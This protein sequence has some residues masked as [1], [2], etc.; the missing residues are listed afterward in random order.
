MTNVLII[1]DEPPAARRLAALIGKHIADAAVRHATGLESAR[2]MLRDAPADMVFLDLN[3]HGRDGFRILDEL[4]SHT[5]VIVVSANTDRA[6]EAFDHGVS[7][8]VAKPV[9][10]QRL[11]VAIDRA[12]QER[13]VPAP[14]LPLRSHRGIDL[15]AFSDITS[16]SAL[17][18]YTEVRTAAGNTYIED[19]SLTQLERKCAGH[20]I[21]IHRSHMV[22]PTHVRDLHK[23]GSKVT[24]RL[25]DGT[26]LPVSRRRT[27]A[28]KSALG[29]IKPSDDR[30]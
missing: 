16:A 29:L 25:S 8:F 1:E 3:L 22:N 23:F 12:R 26:E 9:A 27:R 18:D 7:D 17:D 11:K 21:R 5:A 19:R 20:L 2:V 13:G 24:A 6:L 4:S 10:E 30:E 14:I 28:I 15:V